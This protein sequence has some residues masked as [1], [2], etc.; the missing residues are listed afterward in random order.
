[1]S[2][3]AE[4]GS[5]SAGERQRAAGWGADR[6]PRMMRRTSPT[7]PPVSG[8][9]WG[10]Y[11]ALVL[12]AAIV[13]LPFYWLVRSALA[14]DAQLFSL[15]LVYLPRPTL[16]NFAQLLQQTPLERYLVN[17]LVFALGTT[18]VALVS[19]LLAAYGIVR[20]NVRGKS[21]VLWG[22]VLSMALPPIATVLPLYEVLRTLGMLDTLAGLTVVMGS[23]LV[24]FT[25]WVF[26]AYLQTVPA[27]L[28]EAARIDGAGLAGVFR[29]VV[30]PLMMPVLVTMF[31]INFIVAWNE[32]LYPLAFSASPSS[33]TMSVAITE[34]F[35]NRNPYGRPWNL[36]SALGLVMVVPVMVMV[37]FGQRRIT[38]GL[39]RGG[40]EG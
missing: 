29:H 28:E 5:R 33:K 25:V 32:L 24:P 14:S 19:G 17:S 4:P 39:T 1:M 38:S 37:A 40:V 26:V 3:A 10:Y 7:A 6:R 35:Q 34:V 22:L 23:A 36:I 30:I 11:I 2:A 13:L 18:L 9:T 27:E 20:L 16:D 8:S 31:L 12:F 21:L 15:P